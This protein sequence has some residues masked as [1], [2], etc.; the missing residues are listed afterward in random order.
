MNKKSI[1]QF[2][3]NTLSLFSIKAIELGLTIFLIPY[4]ILKIGID[5]YGVYAFAMALILFLQN[6]LNYGFNLSTVR[7][8]AKNRHHKEAVSA[9]FSEVISVKIF[10][11]VLI[12]LFLLLLVVSIPVFNHQK[13][14]YLFGLFILFGDV[15]SLRWFFLGMEQLKFKALINLF[16]VL[17]YV[18][19]VVLLVRNTTDYYWIPFAEGVAFLIVGII[20]FSIV[21]RTYK[22]KIKL[23]SIL[24]ILTYLKVN[25]SSFINLVVPSTF[26]VMAI[27]LVGVFGMPLQVSLMQIGVK[28]SNI[29]CTLNSILTMVFYPMVH[30]NK[31]I[32]FNSRMVLL[33]AGVILS[34]AMY[35]SSDFLIT[36]WLKS[37]SQTNIYTIIG[38]MQLLSPMPFIVAIISGYGINGLLTL[39]KDALFS[40]ITVIATICMVVLA[41]VL[42]PMYEFYGGAISFLAGRLV[43][44]VLTYFSFKKIRI[45]G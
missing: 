43:Y 25:F 44:A 17:L 21:V 5:N 24:E 34:V 23:I 41:W 28:V 30:R 12:S 13:S 8:I 39:F 33:A 6:V 27:F 26:G 9:I 38:I 22:I 35:V 32:M 4:L 29:F 37:A 20:S 19:L 10:L 14:L 1:Y 42:V 3:E 16:S 11:F 2:S 36:N 45:N 18:L 40:Y 31:T 7:E 15:F